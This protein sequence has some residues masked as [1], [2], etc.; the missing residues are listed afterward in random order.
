MTLSK[1]TEVIFD[2][3]RGVEYHSANPPL[4]D[5]STF[6]QTSLGGDVKYDYARSGNSNRELLEEKLARLEQGK[7]AFAFASGIAAISAVLL[8]FKSGD[9]VILPDDVYGGTFRLTE[10]ILNR[11]N[12]EFTTVDT[13]KLEQIEGAIQSNTK[14]I[15]IETPSNPCFKITDIKG[16]SKIA[17]KHE[18]LVAVDNTFMTPLG[19]SPLL[20]GADIVIHSATKF[21]SGHSDLIAGAV[22]T[23]NEAMSEA[24][25]LIQNGTGNMLSAQDSW[26]L[27]KHLKTFP[28]RFKQSVENAQKIVSF[29]IK[30]DE[31]SEVYY[32]GLTAAHLEQ[33]K[34]GGAV[35]GLRLADESK[36]QQFVDALTLPLVSVSLGGVETI[37]SHPATMSHATL[38]EKVRQERGITFGLFRLS[39][40][41]EDPDELI[42]DI[43]YALKEAFNE[44][45]PHT[46]ER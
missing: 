21:L 40:G 12:I 11:F 26:T 29:L 10:Q 41:L 42:A 8:T 20:L 1:E 15:Y 36:A 45:I 33:A 22:I 31:I 7:F 2:W 34:N 3:R 23:N 24:L 4:Y 27:A 46:I 32:P 6:H 16:V 19:Q 37:L 18:L 9:H 14:L 39:V 30:Q 25:Y 5:S 43:K 38:P 17:E 44:S 28:I 13:T 35:I